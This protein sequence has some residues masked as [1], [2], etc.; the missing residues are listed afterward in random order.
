MKIENMEKYVWRKERKTKRIS[1]KLPS[2]KVKRLDF[3]WI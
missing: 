1:K 2:R 3:L